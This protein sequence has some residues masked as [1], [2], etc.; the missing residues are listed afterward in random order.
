[1]VCFTYDLGHWPCLW[2]WSWFP[3]VISWNCH[4]YKMF[5][6][7]VKKDKKR[8]NSLDASIFCWS[9]LIYVLL[10]SYAAVPFRYDVSVVDNISMTISLSHRRWC[11]FRT[12]YMLGCC[13]GFHSKYTL[14]MCLIRKIWGNKDKRMVLIMIEFI[15]PDSKYLKRRQA[16][17]GFNRRRSLRLYH[18]VEGKNGTLWAN[19][20][21]YQH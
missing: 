18:M 5:D 10:S 4:I 19:T 13:S 11:V 8:V 7:I 17:G 21:L 6:L 9:Y 3:K 1:M 2:P 14:I 15:T 16:D 12:W 20:I